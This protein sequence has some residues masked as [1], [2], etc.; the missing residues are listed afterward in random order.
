MDKTK[1]KAR[2]YSGMTCQREDGAARPQER[3]KRMTT[4]D[5]AYKAYDEAVASAYKARE[6]AVATAEAK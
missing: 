3:S 6:E 5:A 4:K 1:E 2:I